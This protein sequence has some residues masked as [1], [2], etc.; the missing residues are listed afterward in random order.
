MR[1][2]GRSGGG[3]SGAAVAEPQPVEDRSEPLRLSDQSI[4]L[5]VIVVT[6]N[7]RDLA[8]R[9]LSSARAHAAGLA[10]E[11]IVVDSG[12]HD[13]TPDAISALWPDIKVVRQDNVGFA[14]ANNVEIGRAS[15]RERV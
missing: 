11:W 5:S 2:F 9:T 13:G 15:C 14:A 1:A 10:C 3:G 12:S 4:D 6:H 7:G 8:L